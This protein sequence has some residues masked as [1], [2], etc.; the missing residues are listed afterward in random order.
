MSESAL[1]EEV[2][3]VIVGARIAGTAAAVPLA[4]AGRKVVLLDKSRFPSDTLST[5]VLVP[6]GVAELQRM[7][8]LSHALKLGPARS[9]YLAVVSGDVRLRERFTPVHGIDY[10][11]CIPRPEQ[12]L[13]LV[14]AAREAGADVREKCF[15][16]EVVWRDGRGVG[17]R[18]RLA[19]KSYEIRAKLVIGADGRYSR[20]AAEV[21]SWQPYRG[22]LNG[23]GFAFRYMDDPMVGTIE[24]ETLGIYRAGSS[25]ALTLPSC[26]R[27]RMLV[28]WMAPAADIPR[29]RDD[30]DGTWSEKEAED[31][32]LA[33]RIAGAKNA[34]K[35]RTADKLASF[36]RA[37]SGPGWALAGDA[38]HFKDPVAGQGQRDAL[39][40]GRLL[41]E[42]ARA[43]LD[44]PRALDEALKNW[45]R[46]RDRDTI[47]TYHWANRESRPAAPSALVREVFR[48]FEG[49]D[50]P[51][52]T[53]TFNRIRKV[54]KV[55]GPSRLT[56][57]LI[58]ALAQRGVD[59]RE[60]LREVAA[61]LPIE[62]AIRLE[63]WFG[64]FR[65]QG[66]SPS[67]RPGW[68][69]GPAPVAPASTNTAPS[70]SGSESN[71]ASVASP[72]SAVEGQIHS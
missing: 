24:H 65:Y 72:S 29:F 31:P 16:E 52:V 14:T 59:R 64:G 70:R 3:V 66:W 26:P 44:N 55:I 63:T 15:V 18:Y 13:C 51:G 35:L 67:E 8:A 53:D 38:G 17:V 32:H 6:N 36:Y 37:S 10:S 54:E 30:P 41:G 48:T 45:E 60:I 47:S 57:A 46:N 69:I 68:D 28:V 5:H 34:D 21:G 1:I 50:E 42:A 33:E 9:R 71:G 49:D 22:S 61:E 23:R 19:G 40:H 39:R 11:L 56:R 12:D 7:G 4:R 62:L 43:H 20:V 25:I 58:K 27:G 2:D